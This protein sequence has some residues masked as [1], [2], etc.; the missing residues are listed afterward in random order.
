MP[1][2]K[3]ETIR[4]IGLKPSIIPENVLQELCL[5]VSK[6]LPVMFTEKE[7]GSILTFRNKDVPES[8]SHYGRILTM[9]QLLKIL[10]DT[11]TFIK[12]EDTD[13]YMLGNPELVFSQTD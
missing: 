12:L 13:K 11:G 8:F 1:V 9:R 6:K 2:R 3:F 4:N 7:L 10:V 5:Y